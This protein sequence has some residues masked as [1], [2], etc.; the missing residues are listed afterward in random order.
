MQDDQLMPHLTVL[1]AMNVS[2]NL[3]LGNQMSAKGKLIMV[4]HFLLVAHHFHLIHC[5]RVFCYFI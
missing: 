3:K 1:E 2:A 4:C 5:I